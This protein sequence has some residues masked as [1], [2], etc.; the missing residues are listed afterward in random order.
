L[1][2]KDSSVPPGP[3]LKLHFPRLYALE[4]NKVPKVKD[5]WVRSNGSGI[6][7]WNWR[8]HP[9]GRALDDLNSIQTL[10]NGTQINVGSPDRRF[11]NYDSKG[12]FS[13]KRLSSLIKNHILSEDSSIPHHK[14]IPWVP[15]KV[16]LCVWRAAMDRL[17]TYPNLAMRGVAL[18]STICPICNMEEESVSHRF[19][20]SSFSNTIWKNLGR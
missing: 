8:S 12:M 16:N 6:S 9:R 3:C 4:T 18:A 20:T 17:P 1:F 11:W 14:W 13:V 15:I 10:L 2:W 7:S 5:R 19:I